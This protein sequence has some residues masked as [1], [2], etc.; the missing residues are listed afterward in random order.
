MCL[1]SMMVECVSWGF[2]LLVVLFLRN[3]DCDLFPELNKI[4]GRSTH[5][6]YFIVISVHIIL[7]EII[8]FSDVDSNSVLV[9]EH[10]CSNASVILNLIPQF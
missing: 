10:F 1:S 3:C 2:G 4:I 6:E 5:D 8:L 7:I 9:R